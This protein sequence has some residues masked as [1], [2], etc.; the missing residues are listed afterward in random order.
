MNL[1]DPG[2][3]EDLSKS[4]DYPIV[5]PVNS[6]EEKKKSS[7][8]ILYFIVAGI[9][10]F[11]LLIVGAYI[12][13]VNDLNYVVDEL[14]QPSPVPA[15][16]SGISKQKFD[17]SG[18]PTGIVSLDFIKSRPEAQ[19]Y[20]P[21]SEVFSLFGGP[22][23]SRPFKK[24]SSAFYGA[25]LISNDS[26]EQIYQWYKDWML[27][28]G[29]QPRTF[30]RATTQ[31]SLQGYTRDSRERFFVAMDDPESLAGTLGRPVP[32]DEGTVFEIWYAI[33]PASN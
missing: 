21:G 15:R 25:I 3:N 24:N 19:L 11:I 18:L 10:V 7:W 5:Q 22:E 32:Q 33:L 30:P 29:W 4:V 31:T 26:P 28:H 13:L 9:F 1:V 2:S 14:T 23:E 27:S 8:H 12:K 17:S 6:T 16:S 20:Y